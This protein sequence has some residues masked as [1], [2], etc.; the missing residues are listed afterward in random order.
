MRLIDV[1]V[2]GKQALT[3]ASNNGKTLKFILE[4]ADIPKCT[5][6]VRNDGD[7]LWALYQVG[8][9][10]ITDIQ[11][12]ENPPT[13]HQAWGG[14]S[15]AVHPGR[16]PP[17]EVL[18]AGPSTPLPRISL[19]NDL[20]SPALLLNNFLHWMCNEYTVRKISSVTTYWHQ[21]SQVYI[22]YKGRRI[23]PLVLKKVYEVCCS[24]H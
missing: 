3:A 11:L 13:L 10:G 15:T 4:N 24:Q 19:V 12:P 21:L 18:L 14:E 22:K 9:A 20:S 16:F 6:D 23:S 2:L 1:L 8:L 5:W 7:A 17:Y